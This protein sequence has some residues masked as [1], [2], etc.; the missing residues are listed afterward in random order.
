MSRMSEYLKDRTP[1]GFKSDGSKYYE[2]PV[3]LG[4]K[5]LEVDYKRPL[6]YCHKCGRGGR[7]S[8]V[9]PIGNAHEFMEKT[10]LLEGDGLEFFKKL[11]SSS[12]H[13]EYLR[14]KRGVPHKTIENVLRP[15]SGP[16][17]LVVYFPVY[18][19]GS[20]IPANFT[21]RCIMEW[22]SSMT[23]PSSL[24][25][26]RLHSLF[27]GLHRLKTPVETLVLCEGVF[28]AVW[29]RN[30]LALM[31]KTLSD[32]QRE[33]LSRLSP[34]EIRIMLDG[35]T[36]EEPSVLASKLMDIGCPV[37]VDRIPVGDDPDS[38]RD[39]TPVIV[40]SERVI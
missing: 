13:W 35:D 5:K 36:K 6:W 29:E 8:G 10:C 14:K 39:R 9:L 21:G 2:C 33:T 4:R 7:L 22:G 24:F 26:D 31:G 23:P 12:A 40:D 18:R 16:D 1:S 38:F 32:G 17:P 19:L 28:D 3:C 30:R 37:Y 20:D 11:T 25:P 27:W 15:H 34:T